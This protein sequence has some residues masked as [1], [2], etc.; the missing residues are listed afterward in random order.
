MRAKQYATLL[1]KSDNVHVIIGDFNMAINEVSWPAG[2]WNGSELTPTFV[3][4]NPCNA[5][6]SK[7][8]Y[9]FDRCLYRGLTLNNLQLIG[10]QNPASD[11]YG[12]LLTFAVPAAEISK[13]VEINKLEEPIIHDPRKVQMASGN[14]YFILMN[15]D[16]FKSLFKLM[17]GAWV[18]GVD[19][20]WL[21]KPIQL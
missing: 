5:S 10:V 11:H 21:S 17:I 15:S 4:N 12:I 20:K 13:P 19:N 14:S 1:S 9:P 2:G 18:I 3:S 16:L 8:S 6:P 7:F